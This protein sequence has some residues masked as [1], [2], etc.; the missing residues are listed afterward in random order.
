MSA[1]ATGGSPMGGAG[2]TAGAGGQPMG[3][4]G[5]EGGAGGN[6]G[7]GG[8]PVSPIGSSDDTREG[9][10]DVATNPAI[11]ACSG[12][13]SVPGLVDLGRVPVA[14]MCDH[15]SGNDSA[16]PDGTACSAA[17]LCAAGWHIC[18]DSAE[19]DALSPSGCPLPA[20]GPVFWAS[21][22][23]SASVSIDCSSGVNNLHG[24][25]VGIT[26]PV[27]ANCDPFNQ[28]MRHANCT[29]AAGWDCLDAAMHINDELAIVTKTVEGGGVLCCRD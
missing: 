25:G 2:G 12:G 3:G 27:G 26:D 14:P 9:F 13:W 24:C 6:G 7:T 4:A 28:T 17:D 18:R 21:L 15:A 10:V 1:A 8:V 19:V 16:N 29:D 5:G 22:Q 23:G 11:A 20:A